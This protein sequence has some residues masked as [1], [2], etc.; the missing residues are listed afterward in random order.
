MFDSGLKDLIHLFY[1]CHAAQLCVI[2]LLGLIKNVHILEELLVIDL[3][4]YLTP[5]MFL[6]PLY[7]L[8]T[9]LCRS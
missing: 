6:Q 7:R 3:P 2:A 4:W 1:S 9:F 8:A 5:S